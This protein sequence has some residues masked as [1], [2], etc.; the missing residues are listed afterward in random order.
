[1]KQLERRREAI[2]QGGIDWGQ[3][4][5]LAFASLLVDGIPIRVTGQD[6][7]RG[8]FRQPLVV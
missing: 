5:A 4:E 7:E 6:T 3:G 8:F 2:E 1:M